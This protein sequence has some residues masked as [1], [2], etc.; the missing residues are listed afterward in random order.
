M[1]K[2]GIRINFKGVDGNA[3]VLLG[4]CQRALRQ[5][6]K[7]EL[8]PKFAKAATAGDYSHLLNVIDHWFDVVFE[9]EKHYYGVF[10]KEITRE[11]YYAA[12]QDCYKN[13]FV[14]RP[15]KD[16]HHVIA[17]E[18]IEGGKHYLVDKLLIGE[19]FREFVKANSNYL[20]FARHSH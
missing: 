10:G 17:I 3:F 15:G 1:S 4:M 13:G 8:F 19:K 7:Y 18:D 11:Q 12:R 6:G 14:L 16:M 20:I 9:D 5:N 2:T